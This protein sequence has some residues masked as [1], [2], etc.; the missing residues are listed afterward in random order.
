MP[1]KCLICWSCT[2]NPVET[3]WNCRREFSN[4]SPA[5]SAQARWTSTGSA[6]VP[7]WN[8]RSKHWNRPSCLTW[9]WMSSP[10]SFTKQ[11]MSTSVDPSLS[12]FTP[13][14]Q[15][16][17]KNCQKPLRKRTRTLSEATDVYLQKQAKLTST[18]LD[19]TQRHL[20]SCWTASSKCL[21]TTT[22]RLCQSHSN[23]GT[24]WR[25]CWRPRHSKHPHR[26][27]W[28][29]TM[30]WWTLWLTIYAI[31]PTWTRWQRRRETISVISGTKWAIH[32]KTAAVFWPH[33]A[34]WSSPWTCWLRSWTTAKQHG[35]RSRRPSFRCVWWA[36]K[37]PKTR[38]MWCPTLW[39]SCPNYPIILK[40]AMQLHWW[41]LAIPSGQRPTRNSFN[42]NSTLSQTACKMPRS[43]LLVHWPWSIFARTAV[44]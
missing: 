15:P 18:W 42:T 11:E 37:C 34:A 9:P 24:S 38:M 1:N 29:T 40:F 30:H 12:R 36:L 19:D 20:A 27:F 16:C 41:F 13:V 8:Y 44:R 33:N 6:L 21:L 14:L 31:L 39:N 3:T 22:W 26:N 32:S 25:C 5:G 2:C 4:A 28:A 17:Y 7:C 10:R 35:N 23:F 43:L